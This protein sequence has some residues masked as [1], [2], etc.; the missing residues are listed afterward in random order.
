MFQRC[1]ASSNIGCSSLCKQCVCIIS[2]VLA[3]R[4]L[5]IQPCRCVL[6]FSLLSP[7]CFLFLQNDPVARVPITMLGGCC[8]SAYFGRTSARLEMFLFC[9]IKPACCRLRHFV[10]THK[11]GDTSSCNSSSKLR[12]QRRTACPATHPDAAGQALLPVAPKT[13]L[14]NMHV[15]LLS[16]WPLMLQATGTSALLWGLNASQGRR[17]S[18]FHIC[19][20]CCSVIVVLMLQAT[21]T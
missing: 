13:L 14:L 20:S 16:L 5:L 18:L 19:L 12:L 9:H 3:W 6:G 2:R 17:C 8:I 7:G 10:C 11:N 1:A 21:G 15:L 4:L